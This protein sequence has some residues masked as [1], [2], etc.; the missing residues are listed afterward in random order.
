MGPLSEAAL[1]D[2]LRS[3]DQHVRWHAARGLGQIGN[4]EGVDALAE[5]L[6]D[7]SA[8]VRWAAAHALGN[9]D[10][11]ALPAV[12]HML[13][14]HQ[15]TEQ[16]RQVSLHALNSMQSTKAQQIAKPVTEALRG[17][18]ASVLAPLEARRA[19]A[20]LSKKQ[21]EESLQT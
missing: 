21:M 2:A 6:L 11:A 3:P 12:L 16:L 8:E 5:G 20:T 1:L 18:M 7:D 15:V 10:L 14:H 17:R 9:L 13:T 19:L 4:A